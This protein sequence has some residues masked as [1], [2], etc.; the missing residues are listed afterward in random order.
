MIISGKRFSSGR[1]QARGTARCIALPA[2]ERSAHPRGHHPAHGDLPARM[3]PD[4]SFL[5]SFGCLLELPSGP[6]SSGVGAHAAATPPASPPARTAHRDS[7]PTQRWPHSARR[8][9]R[10]GPLVSALR[11]PRRRHAG[12]CRFAARPRRPPPDRLPEPSSDVVRHLRSAP[13]P[14]GRPPEGR[15]TWCRVAGLLASTLRKL[16]KCHRPAVW[17]A[18]RGQRHGRQG[19]PVKGP[20][21][22]PRE[23]DTPHRGEAGREWTQARRPGS[24]AGR[25]A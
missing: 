7:V 18:L 10:S 1:R 23:G 6:V 8:S 9:A 3:L 11:R 22:S 2:V 21:T 20:V 19:D 13:G 24:C 14:T 12:R 5:R 25:S 17:Q 16:N 4:S 15:R